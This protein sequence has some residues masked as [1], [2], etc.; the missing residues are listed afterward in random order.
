MPQSVDQLLKLLEAAKRREGLSETQRAKLDKL[1]KSKPKK[2][3]APKSATV[4]KPKVSARKP[5]PT[6]KRQLPRFVT[7]KRRRTVRSKWL[8]S[9]HEIKNELNKRT[10]DIYAVEYRAH[11]TRY[12]T[13][14]WE[15]HNDIFRFQK[16]LDQDKRDKIVQEQVEQHI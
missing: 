16:G 15:T 5:E 3:P 9:E 13:T 12:K 14:K 2:A 1:A 10:A 11:V 8:T 6:R 7:K 4:P